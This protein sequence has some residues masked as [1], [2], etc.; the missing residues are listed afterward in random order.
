MVPRSPRAVTAAVLRNY[1]ASATPV[2]RAQLKALAFAARLGAGVLLPDQV[3]IG[4]GAESAVEAIDGY[5]SRCLRRKI[6]VSLY[7]GA[8]RANGKPVLQLVTADGETLAFAKVAVNDLTEQLVRRETV[9]LEA[10]S[11][12]RFE[13]LVV[14]EVLHSG[15]WNGHE[16]L[17]QAALSGDSDDVAEALPAAMLE[18]AALG[19]TPPQRAGSSPYWERLEERLAGLPDTSLADQLAGMLPRLQAVA[20]DPE[21]RLGSWHGDWTPW[22]MTSAGRRVA[23][24]DWERFESGVPWGFDALH[25]RLQGSIVRGRT[26]PRSAASALVDEA[27]GLLAPFGVAPPAATFTALAYLT[28]IAARYLRDDLAAA[29]GRLGA[30]DAWLLPAIDQHLGDSQGAHRGR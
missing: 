25:H 14:P 7:V 29:G 23:I 5:L 15:S 30:L 10:L 28:E 11:R 17:V 6:Y 9:A 22:N 16:I 19:A 24:W 1:K 4:S 13:H 3:R 2:T 8:P 20:A 12:Q 27:P 21:V 26:D 18:V